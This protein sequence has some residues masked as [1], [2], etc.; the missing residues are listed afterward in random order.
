MPAPRCEHGLRRGLLI[1][2]T[3][4]VIAIILKALE[5]GLAVSISTLKLFGS[6]IRL[7]IALILILGFLDLIGQGLKAKHWPTEYAICFIVGLSVGIVIIGYF[8]AGFL[9]LIVI[10]AYWLWRRFNR[11]HSYYRRW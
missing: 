2:M 5:E 7:Y 9:I 8:E 1:V 11:P 4:Y 6:Y 10:V 3:S